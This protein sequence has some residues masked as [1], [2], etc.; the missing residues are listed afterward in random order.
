MADLQAIKDSAGNAKLRFT[1]ADPYNSDYDIKFIKNN[2]N[3]TLAGFGTQSI[4]FVNL[5]GG[6]ATVSSGSTTTVFERTTSTTDSI[7]AVVEL[8]DTITKDKAVVDMF[9]DHDGTD[10]YK[11]EFFFDNN[12]GSGI[13]NN[14]IGTFT[15]NINSGQRCLASNGSA[16][17]ELHLRF[18]LGKEAVF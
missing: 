18:F 2:F 10:T 6:T 9:I 3:T 4:G 15:S 12:S 1:P 11:S 13:S 17:K 14:F 7:F 16:G 5:I 8:T